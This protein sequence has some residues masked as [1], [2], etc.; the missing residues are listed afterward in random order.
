MSD[1]NS[2]VDGPDLWRVQLADAEA[3]LNDL[4]LYGATTRTRF[5]NRESENRPATE[6]G[7]RARIAELKGKLGLGGR[8]RGRRMAF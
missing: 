5:N 7:L 4:I 6:A 8:M 3:A 1:P 2:A